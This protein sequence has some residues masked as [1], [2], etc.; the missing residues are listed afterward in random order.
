M[1]SVITNC[2]CGKCPG[3]IPASPDGSFGGQVCHCKCH[4]KKKKKEKNDTR[5]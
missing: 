4:T 1:V 3:T 5:S 2:V